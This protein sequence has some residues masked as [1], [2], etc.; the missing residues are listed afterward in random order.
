MRTRRIPSTNT[1]VIY[2]IAF[3]VIVVAFLLL[4]G[5]TW[6]KEMIHESKSLHIVNWDWIEILV[7]FGLGFLLGLVVSM[8][9]KR[10]S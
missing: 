5:G 1:T 10:N 3:M 8:R 2:F 9:K 4:G 6:V 7:G